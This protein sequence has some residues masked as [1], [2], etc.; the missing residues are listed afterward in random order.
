MLK[1]GKLDSEV[2]KRIIFDNIKFKRDEII[3]RPGIGEDCA[4]IDFGEYICVMSTDPITASVSDI[5]RLSIHISCNDIASNGVQPVG[6]M[7]AVMLPVGTTEED[8]ETIMKQAAAAAE[9]ME[10]EI[11]GGHTEITPAVNKPVI[12]STA[13]G[14]QPKN[15][16]KQE[17]K[18]G[19]K[20]FITKYC[21]IEGTGIIACDC[22]DEVKSILTSEELDEAEAMLDMVSVVKEGVIAGDIGVSAMH[23]ITE[24]GVLG[25]TLLFDHWFGLSPAVSSFVLNIAC[26]VLGWRTLGKSFIAYSAIAACGYS[27]SY[28]ICEL[29]PPL[30]PGIAS[31]P[32]LASVVGALFIGGGA[33]MAPMRSHIFHLFKTE[34]I[35]TPV[36]FW[37]G[38]RSKRE[39]FYEEQFEEIEKEFPNFKFHIALSEPK[40]EDN[41]KGYTGFIHQVIFENYLKNHDAPEDIEYYLCGPPMMTAAMTKMLDGLGVPEEN[42]MY[43][44]F[45]A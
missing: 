10:V 44:N 37:Y 2:L 11:I 6:I 23:D 14:R 5:G 18:T 16:I 43:D 28:A 35:D 15:K 45:G 25:A 32:L 4:E 19:D 41:W 7:L 39:I 40:E 22:R 12:V 20:I 36:T 34:K 1:T 38:A 33:G 24:G 31:L 17:I 8:I 13:I 3:T 26:Y 29:F 30:W 21:G 27:A 42:I 9:L